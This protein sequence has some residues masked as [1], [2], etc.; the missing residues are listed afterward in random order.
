MVAAELKHPWGGRS[1]LPEEANCVNIQTSRVV[2]TRIGN[3]LVRSHDVEHLL[4]SHRAKHRAK[5]V[6]HGLAFISRKHPHL[7]SW[8][9]NVINGK[10]GPYGLAQFFASDGHASVIVTR[11]TL[12]T[13]AAT[14]ASG[15][16]ASLGSSLRLEV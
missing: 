10:I 15:T 14:L 9:R 11:T 8:P 7:H 13:K 4:I 5:Q 2:R 12:K 16:N 6:M 3:D 1:W